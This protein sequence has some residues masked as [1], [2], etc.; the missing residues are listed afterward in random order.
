MSESGLPL[1]EFGHR[2][3]VGDA[4]A[5]DVLDGLDFREK[6]GYTR[7][8][9]E[10]EPAGGGSAVTALLYRGTVDNPNFD[11]A[12]LDDL[13]AAA[14]T[15]RQSVGPSGQNDEYLFKL[16]AWLDD[17]GEG[18]EHVAGLVARVRAAGS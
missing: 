5:A 6:G 12:V 14:T 3:R 9:V 11:A 10:V 7:D 16:A 8:L 4:D 1:F 15:I 13:D 2:Y 17:V 18:D